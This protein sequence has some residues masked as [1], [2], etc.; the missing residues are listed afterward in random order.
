MKLHRDDPLIYEGKPGNYWMHI[1]SEIGL[2][3]HFKKEGFVLM[4]YF[5][6]SYGNITT[7]EPQFY[8]RTDGLSIDKLGFLKA[9][10]R[11]ELHFHR[12]LS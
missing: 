6:K 1:I 2:L 12:T 9:Y 10:H 8:F 11:K 7:S 4:S 5:L 3:S